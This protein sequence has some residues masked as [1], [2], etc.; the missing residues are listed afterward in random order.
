MFRFVV[1]HLGPLLGPSWGTLGPSWAVLKPSWGPSGGPLGP[2]WGDLGCLLGRFGARGSRTG[3]S[4]KQ[5]KHLENNRCFWPIGAL[6]G[7]PLERSWS[8]VWAFWAGLGSSRASWGASGLSWRLLGPLGR[9]WGALL[10]RMGALLA[11]LASCK[12][13]RER[14]GARQS[15]QEFREFGIPAF[16]VLDY[17]VQDREPLRA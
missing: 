9:L 10:A 15:A 16:G 17:W 7:G 14:R 1:P 3:E 11:R 12:S 2:F 13:T 4:A 5:F 8:F 6:L